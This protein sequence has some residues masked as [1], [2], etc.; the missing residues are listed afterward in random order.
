MTSHDLISF[1][2]A[3]IA[4]LNPIGSV[5]IFAGMASDR[6][7]TDRH[8]I[9]VRAAVA[10]AVILLVTVWAGEFVLKLFD[11]GIPSLQVAGGVMIALISLSMLQSTQSAIHDTKDDDAKP[12]P[13]RG[14]D[15]DIAIVPLA[16][17]MI[18]GP[19]AMVTAIVYTHQHKGIEANL[20]MS[21]VCAVLAAVIGVCLLGAGPI[22]RV[23]GVKGMDIVTKLMGVILL[24]IA[25]GMVAAG[26]KGLLPG[27]AG[28]PA[29]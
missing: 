29:G 3:M 22:T 15:Q 7:T 19:G 1:A 21:V 26:A 14:P 24:A 9:A 20:E 4:I 13:K 12:T 28:T 25:A 16:M 18:A 27:L 11:V 8:S 23:L 6:S 10:V 2:T 5:A 17:P